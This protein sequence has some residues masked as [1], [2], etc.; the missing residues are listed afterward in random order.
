M[1]PEY[2]PVIQIIVIK[3]HLS[4]SSK[5][6]IKGGV[7]VVPCIL[8]LHHIPGMAVTHALFR[9]GLAD[10][11]QAL[12]TQPVAEYLHGLRDTFADPDSLLQRADDFMGILLLQFVIGDI[13]TDE[14][15]DI[16]F[17]FVRGKVLCR[18]DQTVHPGLQG[19]FHF[20][21]LFLLKHILGYELDIIRMFLIT[22]TESLHIKNR[23]VVQTKPEEQIRQI[24]S[25]QPQHW[26]FR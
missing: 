7:Q 22:V 24:P 9:I 18:L 3:P 11:N 16:P 15:M 23:R 5:G 14:I 13:G 20:L 4:I 21:N 26:K 19:I 17:L 6:I 25:I 8:K 10:G 1:V 2:H 12:K